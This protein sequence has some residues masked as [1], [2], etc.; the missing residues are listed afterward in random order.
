MLQTSVIS[1]NGGPRFA[2]SVI[3]LH[4][5]LAQ[6]MYSDLKNKSQSEQSSRCIPMTGPVDPA[7][8]LHTVHQASPN[9]RLFMTGC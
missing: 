2:Y 3:K 1:C 7:Y 5:V 9:W 8:I 6:N 4:I